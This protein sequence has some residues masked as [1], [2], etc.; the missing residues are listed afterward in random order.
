MIFTI[1]AIIKE[2]IFANWNAELL[3]LI[4]IL[5][6]KIEKNYLD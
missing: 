1:N 5:E 6:S 4:L 3:P 2:R